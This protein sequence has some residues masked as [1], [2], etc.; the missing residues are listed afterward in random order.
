MLMPVQ[1]LLTRILVS[2]NNVGKLKTEKLNALKELLTLHEHSFL[3]NLLCY[4]RLFGYYI[5]EF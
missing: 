4:L 1:Q 3:V 2:K 5:M